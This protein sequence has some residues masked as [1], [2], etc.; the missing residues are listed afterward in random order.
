MFYQKLV[1]ITERRGAGYFVL[2]DPDAKDLSELREFTVQICEGDA[3]AILVGGSLLIN[4]Q[5]DDKI[6]VIK[7][8]ATIP[9]ILFPGSLKQ[10]SPHAD[11]VLF[12]S[13]ISGRNPNY[14]IGE[15]VAGAPMIRRMGI[16]PI[17][18]GYMLMESGRTTTA[19][20]MSNTRP[21]PSDKPDIAMAHAL[22]AQYLGMKMFY[23][24]AGSGAERAVPLDII[25]STTDFV[26]IPAI[27]GGGIREPEEA[28]KRVDNGASFIV[29]GNVL[30]RSNNEHLI[31]EFADA[32]H[33]K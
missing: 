28:R 10:L 32:V 5:Y 8:A 23:L 30:E 29:T 12:L 11:A 20:F 13:L 1:E 24:E 17:S 15:Q 22:A 26:D 27:V 4:A 14:L 9:V 3:D 7:D 31:R 25:K 19:Q 2:I 18:T 21:I 16:E 33:V 6:K